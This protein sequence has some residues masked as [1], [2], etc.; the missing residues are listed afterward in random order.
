MSFRWYLAPL[1]FM[2]ACG[3]GA[4][5]PVEKLY[6]DAE[7][8]WHRGAHRKALELAD[9]GWREWSSR[10]DS[11][12]HW[13]FRLLDAEL[14]ANDGSAGKSRDLLDLGPAEPPTP[15]LKARLLALRAV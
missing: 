15:E 12:W 7:E 8:Q 4:L 11:Q 3:S 6:R 1:P 2:L 9:R 10:P 13:K 14:Q 5:P